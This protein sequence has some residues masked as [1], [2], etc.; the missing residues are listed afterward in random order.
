MNILHVT[1]SHLFSGKDGT[2]CGMNTFDGFHHAMRHARWN[3][4]TPD[5]IVHTGDIAQE[6]TVETYRLAHAEI[7]ERFLNVPIMAVPGNHDQNAEAMREVFGEPRVMD[8]KKWNIAFI[9]LDTMGVGKVGGEC[10]ARDIDML[11]HWLAEYA[12]RRVVVC[13]HHP[14]ES[15][16]SPEFDEHIVDRADEILELLA[17]HAERRMC[18]YLHGHIHQ[19]RYS[20]WKGVEINATPS[21]CFQFKVGCGF[22]IDER[23]P[24]CYRWIEF[25]ENGSRKLWSGVPWWENTIDKDAVAAYRDKAEKEMAEAR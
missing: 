1:D 23:E 18:L 24:P 6:S 7:R 19:P 17:K 3:Q 15:V 14:I 13:G 25:F 10:S 9:P 20:G 4:G 5:L 11:E 16:G 8:F 2:L 22:D 21:T 12:D